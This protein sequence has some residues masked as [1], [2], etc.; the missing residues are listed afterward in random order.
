MLRLL[1]LATSLVAVRCAP[2]R[3][4]HNAWL[5]SIRGGGG[6]AN[7]GPEPLTPAE[8]EAANIADHR[9]ECAKV[10]QEAWFGQVRARRPRP[11]WRGGCESGLAEEDERPTR[12]DARKGDAREQSN[13]AAKKK[14]IAMSACP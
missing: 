12:Q 14:R 2:R 7:G 5:S 4:H 8:M 13:R 10:E 1:A 6:G 9:A 3:P 11:L